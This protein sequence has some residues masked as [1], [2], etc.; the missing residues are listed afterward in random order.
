M[1]K[2][3]PKI[4]PNPLPIY[5]SNGPY[6]DMLRVSFSDGSTQIYDLRVTQPKPILKEQL[7][8]FTDVCV[9]YKKTG[10]AG[11]ANRPMEKD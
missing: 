2:N 3:P 11:T 8:S 10:A 4:L 7:D 9:G 1:K 5:P 6:P